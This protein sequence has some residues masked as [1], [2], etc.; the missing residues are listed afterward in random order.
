LVAGVNAAGY[1]LRI[2]RAQGYVGVLI[3]DLVTKGTPEPY[4]MMTSRAEYRLLLRQ[5]NADLRLTPLGYAAGLVSENRYARFLLK[6]EAIESEIKRLKNTIFSPETV[7]PLLIEKNS[8]PL[9]SG[10][11]LADLI[12]RPELS[13]GDVLCVCPPAGITQMDLSADTAQTVEYGVNISTLPPFVQTAV[14]EQVNIQIKYEGYIAMATEQAEQFAKAENRPLPSDINYEGITG[15]RLE[16][17]QKLARLRP[18][19]FGQAS[20][21]TGVSPADLSILMV[22]AKARTRA[23]TFA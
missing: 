5:D 6:R 18:A 22:Y 16:A 19:N 21:I 3:D 17:R 7:N 12:K 15:L 8:A 11:R 1:P 2:T 14:R 4:R 23:Q 13:Y 10:A 9:T 20:R